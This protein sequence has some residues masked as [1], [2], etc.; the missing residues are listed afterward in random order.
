[1]WTK[2]VMSDTQQVHYEEKFEDAIQQLRTIHTEQLKQLQ[3][4]IYEYKKKYEHAI[5]DLMQAN[6]KIAVIEAKLVEVNESRDLIYNKYLD[7]KRNYDELSS[8]KTSVI[9][10]L[11]GQRRESEVNLGADRSSMNND[12]YKG[13]SFIEKQTCSNSLSANGSSSKISLSLEN[14]IESNYRR[15]ATPNR[16]PSNDYINLKHAKVSFNL[17]SEGA[18]PTIKQESHILPKSPSVA[19]IIKQ[20]NTEEKSNNLIDTSIRGHA[21]NSFLSES[22]TTGDIQQSRPFTTS[23]QKTSTIM[24]NLDK[25][26]NNLPS[27]RKE[28]PGSNVNQISFLLKDEELP[29]ITAEQLYLYTKKQLNS[30]EFNEF[31]RNIKRLNQQEQS[32]EETLRNVSQIFGPDRQYLYRQFQRLVKKGIG[33]N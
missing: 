18:L 24:N 4:Q 25:D 30:A 11:E 14:N 13:F 20:P 29:Q 3:Y 8:L 31:A 5:A 33:T 23:P 16:V 21:T 7:V 19:S 32:V 12:N 9:S 28:E 22:K 26:S 10:M 27:L 6:E 1:M 2:K 17:P 15:V